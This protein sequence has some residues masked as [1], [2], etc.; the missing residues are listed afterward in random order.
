[1]IKKDV[2]DEAVDQWGSESQ[3][4]ML[5]EEI[6]EFLQELNKYRRHETYREG[7]A[8]E[9]ADLVIML[10]QICHMYDIEHHYWWKKREK[11]KRLKKKLM[12]KDEED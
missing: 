6:G 10:E 5:H 8:E 4:G 1:M 7:L 9:L 12:V 2:Y 3:I 11:L